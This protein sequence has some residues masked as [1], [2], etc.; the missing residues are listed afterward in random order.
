[1]IKY[2]NGTSTQEVHFKILHVF[3]DL[4]MIIWSIKLNIKATEFCKRSFARGN[5][6]PFHRL[7]KNGIIS[8]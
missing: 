3:H 2:Y 5:E 7:G 6:Q 4:N 1:M 8:I